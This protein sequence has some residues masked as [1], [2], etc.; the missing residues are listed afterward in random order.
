MLAYL[1][2]IDGQRLYQDYVRERSGPQPRKYDEI[3]TPI[4]CGEQNAAF[5]VVANIPTTSYFA[6]TGKTSHRFSASF[7]ASLSAFVGGRPLA[8]FCAEQSFSLPAEHQPGV[9]DFVGLLK[10]VQER[11]GNHPVAAIRL[12]RQLAYD[13]HLRHLDSKHREEGDEESETPVA[14]EEGKADARFEELA[15]MERIA[16]KFHSI[17]QFLDGLA[18][19]KEQAEDSSK[20]KRDCV[21][22]LTVHKSKGLESPVVFVMGMTEGIFPHKRSTTLN[23]DD[24]PIILSGLAEERRL[25][26]VAFTRARQLLCLTCILRYRS[27]DATP[28]RFIEE[29]GLAPTD[30]DGVLNPFLAD[31]Y[32]DPKL[33]DPMLEVPTLFD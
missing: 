25:A 16:E 12:L 19:L 7:Y 1:A 33:R 24:G 26:Y 17:R 29:A 31:K 3:F 10:R 6:N 11:C 4:V 15:E 27:S 23:T 5:R 20:N 30:E 22:L 14:Q 8:Q 21:S 28:S 9:K 2:L 18:R 32:G 13:Q